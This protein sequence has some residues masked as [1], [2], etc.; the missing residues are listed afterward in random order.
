MGYAE[1]SMP[2]RIYFLGFKKIDINRDVTSEEN[3][4]YSRSRK[5]P[6]VE[7]EEPEATRVRDMEIEEKIPEY[8][9]DHDM[10]KPEEYVEP[11]HENNS[12]KR[13]QA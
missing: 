6:I 2:Y 12:H 10:A 7:A 13:K 1:S 3:S 4:T 5:L 8:H 11:L 9:E